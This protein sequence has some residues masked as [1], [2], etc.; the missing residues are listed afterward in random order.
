MCSK[1]VFAIFVPEAT[2]H[3]AD[4]EATV[5][6]EQGLSPSYLG[7]AMLNEPTG[8]I[9]QQ[10]IPQASL[11]IISLCG[12]VSRVPCPTYCSCF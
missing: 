1:R 7:S 2:L 8:A 10:A 3:I 6:C 5:F 11:N 4:A 12:C 9:R